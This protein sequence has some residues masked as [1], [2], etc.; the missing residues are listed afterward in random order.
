MCAARC[1]GVARTSSEPR[2]SILIDTFRGSRQ[3]GRPS[4]LEGELF[5]HLFCRDSVAPD[6]IAKFFVH[7]GPLGED[8]AFTAAPMPAD[9]LEIR[10]I[11]RR[12]RT[13]R[14][15]TANV[16]YSRKIAA[17]RC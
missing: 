7:S 9:L 6:D 12:L 15:K 10:G 13:W 3:S 14:T 16:Y 5:I 11:D 17:A 4:A 8:D 1:R 2:K